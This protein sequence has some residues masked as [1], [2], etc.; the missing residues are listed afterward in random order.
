MATKKWLGLAG[1][2]TAVGAGVALGVKK[3]RQSPDKASEMFEGAR[4][5]VRS[6]GGTEPVLH[7]EASSEPEAEPKADTAEG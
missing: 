7:E 1:V 3:L 4:D 6:V 5:K 2:A